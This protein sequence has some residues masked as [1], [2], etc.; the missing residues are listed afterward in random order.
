MA[1]TCA[2]PEE[3]NR[4]WCWEPGWSPCL[5]FK[6][7][8]FRLF[9]RNAFYCEAKRL[10]AGTVQKLLTA[11]IAEKTRSTQRKPKLSHSPRAPLTL[12]RS[13]I[14]ILSAISGRRSLRYLRQKDCTLGQFKSP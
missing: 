9:R 6:T 4:Y 1:Q 8:G 12:R 5:P 11:E 7:L 10:S 13:L 2:A 3:W 14:E